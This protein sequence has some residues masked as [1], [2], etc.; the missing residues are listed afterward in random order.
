MS[1]LPLEQWAKSGQLSDEKK[2][3]ELSRQFEAILLRQILQSAQK[4]VI[5]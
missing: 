4:P 3:G 5:K 2:I 1:G